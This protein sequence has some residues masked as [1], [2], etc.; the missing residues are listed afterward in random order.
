MSYMW[1]VYDTPMSA[2]LFGI[3]E[4]ERDKMMLRVVDKL[5]EL[6]WQLFPAERNLEVV[7]AA[8]EALFV[9]AEAEDAEDGWTREEKTKNKTKTT[10]LESRRARDYVG[11]ALWHHTVRSTEYFSRWIEMKETGTES[12]TELSVSDRE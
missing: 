8:T 12:G 6:N 7:R 10:T 3:T 4:L 11:G 5:V 9:E 1:M 2:V